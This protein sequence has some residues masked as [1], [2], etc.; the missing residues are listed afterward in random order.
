MKFIIVIA[1]IS[2][3]IGIIR[4]FITEMGLK[5]PSFYEIQE[6]NIFLLHYIVIVSIIL[7]SFYFIGSILLITKERLSFLI[8]FLILIM[9]ILLSLIRIYIFENYFY[10]EANFNLFIS[11]ISLVFSISILFFI[12]INNKN[13]KN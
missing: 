2:G 11:S 8:F 4:A 1:A 3:L 5:L 7:N 10:M 6:E 9:D 13:F 12:S